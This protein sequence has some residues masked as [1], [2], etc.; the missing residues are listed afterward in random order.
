MQITRNYCVYLGSYGL[1]NIFSA[2]DCIYLAWNLYL[3]LCCSYHNSL[4]PQLF[5][6]FDL[7]RSDYIGKLA[8]TAYVAHIKMMQYLLGSLNLTWFNKILHM[9]FRFSIA[10]CKLSNLAF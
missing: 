2:L 10:A 7:K 3:I 5:F 9:N 1:T 8:T 4:Y 6:I